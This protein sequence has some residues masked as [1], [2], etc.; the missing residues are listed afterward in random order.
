MATA[1]EHL[2]GRLGQIIQNEVG[3]SVAATRR[4]I[5]NL[6]RTTIIAAEAI[7]EAVWEARL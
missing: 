4:D 3:G 7:I 5:E 2:K 1:R 6:E